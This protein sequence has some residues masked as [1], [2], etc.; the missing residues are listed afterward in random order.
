M[1]ATTAAF[2]NRMNLFA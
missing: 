2:R 1:G